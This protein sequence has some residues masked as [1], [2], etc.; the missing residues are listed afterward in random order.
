MKRDMDLARAIL[1]KIEDTLPERKSYDAENFEVP[2]YDHDQVHYHIALLDEAGLI[3]ALNVTG[4]NSA[5]PVMIP[6]S[7]TWEGHEFIEAARDESIW[8]KAKGNIVS[9][10]VGLPFD[11]LKQLLL[12]LI[13]EAIG[14]GP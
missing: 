9:T 7:L 5:V 1:L 4:G 10:G 3:R 6:M 11:V 8:N 13:K 2:D 14:G 12:K